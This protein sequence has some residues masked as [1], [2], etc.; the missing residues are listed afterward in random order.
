MKL[1]EALKQTRTASTRYRQ[2]VSLGGVD[3]RVLH[4]G[5]HAYG[6]SEDSAASKGSVPRPS[7]SRAGAAEVP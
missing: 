7:E 1:G 4:R 6:G 2:A 3:S 5:G